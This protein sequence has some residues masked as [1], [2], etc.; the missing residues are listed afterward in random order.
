MSNQ[1]L[2]SEAPNSQAPNSEPLSVAVIGAG[3]LGGYFGALL[4]QAGHRVHFTARG[5]HLDALRAHGLRITGQTECT[6]PVDVTED[7]ARIGPVDLVLLAVKATQLDE[8]LPGLVPLLGEQTAVVTL[9]NGVEAPSRVAEALGRGHVLPG[10]VR[11][12]TRIAQPGVIDHMGGPGSITLAE[13]DNAATG[14]VAAIRRALETA[15]VPS[16]VPDDIWQ[17]LWHKVMFVVPTGLLG[18][19]AQAPL[20]VQR[21]DLRENLAAIMAEV[22]AVGQAQGVELADAVEQTLAFADRMPAEATT[23]MHRD[24]AAGIPGELDPLVGGVRRLGRQAGVRTP[25]FDLGHA[26]LE[27]RQP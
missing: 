10:I 24:L 16:P 8:V 26:L 18:A 3:A 20:G 17:D 7:P 11:V 22:R 13:W 9:Q 12:Y 15:G 25:L 2:N 27:R 21:T 5:A 4:Q 23:S 14:R 19:L 1:P 6:L